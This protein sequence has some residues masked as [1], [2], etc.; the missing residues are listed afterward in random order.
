MDTPSRDVDGLLHQIFISPVIY[1]PVS[2]PVADGVPVPAYTSS[3]DAIV[4]L[5]HKTLPGWV[6]RL[7]ECS[8]SDDAWLMPDMNHPEH[9]ATFQATWP[10]C[11]D[12]LDDGPGLDMSFSPAGRPA[13]SLAAVFIEVQLALRNE[14]DPESDG[15]ALQA[16]C[17]RAHSDTA[18]RAFS[19]SPAEIL[20]T[21]EEDVQAL[22]TELALE[23]TGEIEV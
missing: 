9:G 5:V 17:R 1:M 12:P 20:K 4:G 6:W 11:K 15:L 7:C 16:L 14:R 13:L 8:V 18:L 19:T 21:I 10:D 22:R 2:G 23:P 3:I